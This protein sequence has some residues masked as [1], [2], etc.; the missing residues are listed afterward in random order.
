MTRWMNT[1]K[2]F[3]LGGFLIVAGITT[4]YEVL[5]VWP[6]KKCDERGAWWDARDRECL[7]P[8]PIWRMTGRGLVNG[9]VADASRSVVGGNGHRVA[10][11]A[12]STSAPPLSLANRAATNS[13]SDNRLR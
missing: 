12:Q 6:V 11:G 3:V 7:D 5:Y 8:I 2:L 1:A 10:A 13:R 9:P 4:G